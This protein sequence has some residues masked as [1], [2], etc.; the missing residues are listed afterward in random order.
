MCYKYQEGVFSVRDFQKKWDNLER[1]VDLQRF[2]E[3]QSK[4]KI[5]CREAVWWRDACLLYFQ[6]FSRLPFPADLERPV[7]E[8]DELKKIRVNMSY[9]N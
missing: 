2:R 4:L 7:N 6:T 1:F 9:H 5:Q 3:V 8:L